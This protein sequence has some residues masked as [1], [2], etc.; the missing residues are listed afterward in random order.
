MRTQVQGVVT[1]AQLPM[2]Y[3]L[4]RGRS[5]ESRPRTEP[6]R[7]KEKIREML[8][9][10]VKE[11]VQRQLKEQQDYYRSRPSLAAR[12]MEQIFGAGSVERA[13]TPAVTMQVYEQLEDRIRHEWIRKGR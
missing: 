13:L 6:G 1:A 3:A 4:P 12:Q 9:P 11:A 2:E 7:E 8:L 5:A 10:M